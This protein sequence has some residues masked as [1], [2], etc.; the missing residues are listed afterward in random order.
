[1]GR[2]VALTKPVTKERLAVACRPGDPDFLRW[3][4]V[5][6]DELDDAGLLAAWEERYFDHVDWRKEVPWK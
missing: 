6:I 1:V 5:A 4:N 3:L 2:F